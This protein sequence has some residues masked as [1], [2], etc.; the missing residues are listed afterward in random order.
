[1]QDTST[2]S[3]PTGIRLQSDADD[4]R[5]M[6]YFDLVQGAAAAI[7]RVFFLD[8]V[9]GHCSDTEIMDLGD[10]AGWLVPADS[11][12][13]FADRFLAFGVADS[14]ADAAFYAFAAWSVDASGD[15]EVSF[16]EQ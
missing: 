16:D 4:R 7:G 9:D 6:R 8:A 5:F 12:D 1:M 2:R 15:I 11:A 10:L 13:E 14:E 3:L